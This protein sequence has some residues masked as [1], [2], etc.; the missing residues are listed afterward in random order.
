MKDSHVNACIVVCTVL[1]IAIMLVITI[2]MRKKTNK[3]GSIVAFTIPISSDPE[4]RFNFKTFPLSECVMTATER[5][6]CYQLLHEV[7]TRLDDHGVVYWAASGTLLGAVRHKGMIPWD[8]DIDLAVAYD[9]ENMTKVNAALDALRVM[10]HPCGVTES[11]IKILDRDTLVFPWLDL[12][13]VELGP[14]NRYRQCG[15][16]AKNLWPQ[17]N[18]NKEHIFP[19]RKMRF[20]AHSVWTPAQSEK[21]VREEF[22]DNWKTHMVFKA[23]TLYELRK[24]Q[25]NK[26]M[27]T[28]Q[29]R[30]HIKRW[31]LSLPPNGTVVPL[32]NVII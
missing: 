3:V 8:D 28:P 4:P 25:E 21:V 19:L 22:G 18:Y 32:R 14:D 13:M 26:N 2:A 15:E 5:D 27:P 12:L 31:K 29:I 23:P 11:G 17:V 16:K 20:G 9:Q 30:E 1:F 24:Y 7:T 6:R 10:G